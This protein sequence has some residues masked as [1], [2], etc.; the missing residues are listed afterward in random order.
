M[1]RH[2]IALA[3][4]IRQVSHDLHPSVL[5]HAGL[6]TALSVF[7][8]QFQ[9]LHT[10]AVTYTPDPELG[11]VDAD[12]SLCLYRIAQEALRNVAKHAE[13]RHAGVALTR[14]DGSVQLSITDDGK[15]F[16]LAATRGKADGLGLVSI[17]ERVRLLRGSVQI[18]TQHGGGTQVRVRIPQTLES[19]GLSLNSR[20]G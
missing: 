10:I 4:D 1:Q 2:I 12:T 15:G 14:A 9:R 19:P 20:S 7:C 5:R 3:E 17:D 13:A 8:D 18:E 6:V 11:H 16:D